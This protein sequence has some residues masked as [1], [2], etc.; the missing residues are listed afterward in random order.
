MTTFIDF[1]PSQV[2]APQ[3][4]VTLDGAIYAVTVTWNLFAQRY[5]I[6][7]NDLGGNLIVAEALVGSPVGIE[8]E[9]MTWANGLVTVTT[10]DPH[11]LSI[12]QSANLTIAGASPDSY[13][14]LREMFVINDQSMT[15]PLADDPGF[16]TVPGTLQQNID[17]VAGLFTSTLVYREPNK[18]F[19]VSP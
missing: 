5:Y 10:I 19:E 18:Q 13:N 8:I 7:I 4:Q 17:L 11:F 1:V 12:G 9:S 3:F 15:F 16:M 14:G 6:N 2:I